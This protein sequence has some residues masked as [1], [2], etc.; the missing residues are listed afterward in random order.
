[1]PKICKLV[2]TIG[3]RGLEVLPTPK[4]AKYSYHCN[5][6]ALATAGYGTAL[7]VVRPLGER[8]VPVYADETRPRLQGAD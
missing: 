8:G 3:D 6:G 5:A 7:G 4:K 2:E 1:M